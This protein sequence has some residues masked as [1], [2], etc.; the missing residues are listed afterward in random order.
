MSKK[1]LTGM[2]LGGAATYAAWK[3]MAP[4][5]KEALKESINE[6][7]NEV[8]DYV[9]DYTLDALD[10]VDDLM[11]DSNLNDKV[12]GAADAV[13]N[14]TGKVK[15]SA[16][17]VVN[18]I[19]NDDFDKQTAEIR[20]ELAKNKEADEDNND[21]IIDATNDRKPSPTEDDEV[22]QDDDKE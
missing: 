16:N 7:F 8:A 19:T 3:K 1:L 17:K 4:A 14:V 12:S 15:N 10:I 9:T 11:S 13:N 21:I 5:K 6:K 20:E 22:S 2:L 18:H